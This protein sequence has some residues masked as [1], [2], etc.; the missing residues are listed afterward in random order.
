MKIITP[1]IMVISFPV[2]AMNAPEKISGELAT[3]YRYFPVKGEYGNTEQLHASIVIK[4]EY[5]LSWDSDRRVVSVISYIR[6]DQQDSQRTHG[7]LRELSLVSSWRSMD[8]RLGVS[9]VFWGVTESQHLV[10]VINQA[11]LVEN[12][13]GE[14]KLG[15]P[16]INPTWVTRLGNLDF[17]ILPYFRE[18]TFPGVNGRFRSAMVVDSDQAEYLHPDKNRHVDRAMRWSTSGGDIDWALS[19][20]QGTDREPIFRLDSTTSRLVPNRSFAPSR[21]IQQSQF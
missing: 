14:Q 13:D 9:S 11:D 1:F 7:D 5:T 17:F 4:P 6:L 8:L 2:F 21:E 3:E 12:L 15:Q 18:R 16:M 19:Y 20:F 10:D